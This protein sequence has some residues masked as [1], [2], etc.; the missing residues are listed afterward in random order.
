MKQTKHPVGDLK[1]LP[2]SLQDEYNCVEMRCRA[3]EHPAAEISEHAYRRGFQQGLV[4][5]L[6]LVKWGAT[7]ADLS[8][9]AHDLACD[10]R[11]NRKPTGAYLDDFLH[12]CR[13]SIPRLKKGGARS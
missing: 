13:Q 9:A 12:L 7:E 10:M 11:Y 8:Q 5:A 1:K 6:R 3:N 4:A 2:S